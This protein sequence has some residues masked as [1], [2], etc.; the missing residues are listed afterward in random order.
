MK[1]SECAATDKHLQRRAESSERLVRIVK[2]IDYRRGERIVKMRKKCG[3]T[4]DTLADAMRISRPAM[5]K[6]EN[7]GDLLISTTMKHLWVLDI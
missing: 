6:I 4:Q 5:S 7:G 2:E 3:L 1:F